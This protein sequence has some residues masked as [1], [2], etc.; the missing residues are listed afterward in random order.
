MS[1]ATPTLRLMPD[2]LHAHLVCSLCY[3]YFR[4]VHTL[5][6]C[7]HSFCKSCLLRHLHGGSR[8]CPICDMDLG[9]TP[10]YVFDRTLNALL[11]KLMPEL[12]ASDAALEAAFMHSTQES[13]RRSSSPRTETPYSDMAI[14]VVPDTEADECD[15]LPG[16][17]HA[18]LKLPGHATVADVQ[19]LIRDQTH[20]EGRIELVCHRTVLSPD[21]M[22]TS[23][24]RKLWPESSRMVWRYRKG[25]KEDIEHAV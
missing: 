18:Q 5:S 3:G 9:P 4:D 23:V 12:E 15:Q 13:P 19:K 22:L 14:H 7:L 10:H 2:A 24:K 6:E 1:D 21:A 16:L 20:E 11:Q 17:N 25:R 8:R